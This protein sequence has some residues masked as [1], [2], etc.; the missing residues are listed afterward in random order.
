MSSKIQINCS[1]NN[2]LWANMLKRHWKINSNICKTIQHLEQTITH[3][4]YNLYKI[5]PYTNKYNKQIE[6]I[7]RLKI[8]IKK[9][10][11]SRSHNSESKKHISSILTKTTC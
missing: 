4:N 1:Q 8:G 6:K 5:P 2:K 7:S 9:Y 10:E 3:E 11:K